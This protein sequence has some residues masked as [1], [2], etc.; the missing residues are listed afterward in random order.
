MKWYQDRFS[1]DPGPSQGVS[2]GQGSKSGVWFPVINSCLSIILTVDF[3]GVAYPVRLNNGTLTTT[4]SPSL[5][6]GYVEVL[7]NGTWGTV[8]DDNWAIQD[9]NV[10]CRE[11]GKV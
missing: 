6:Y 11:L 9:A 5:K 10:V 4:T 7:I 8:C 3:V 2:R 1:L